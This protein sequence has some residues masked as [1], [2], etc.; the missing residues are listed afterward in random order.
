MDMP[1]PKNKR[2]SE[3]QLATDFPKVDDLKV[4]ESLILMTDKFNAGIRKFILACYQ[5]DKLAGIWQ[6]VRNSGVYDH[7]GKSKT[8]RKMVEFPNAYV[9]EFVNEVLTAQYGKDWLYDNKALQ[10]ELVRPWHVVSKL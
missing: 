6:E 8:Y 9:F 4:R 3:K 2:V 1:K 7:G 5:S 10:H